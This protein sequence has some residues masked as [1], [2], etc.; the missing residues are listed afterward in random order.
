MQAAKTACFLGSAIVEMDEGYPIEEIRKVTQQLKPVG[1]GMSGFHTALIL[2]F[3]GEVAYGSEEAC[4]FAEAVQAHL[5]FG[6]LLASAELTKEFGVWDNS[7]VSKEYWEDHL[8]E[9]NDCLSNYTSLTK[10]EIFDV[11]NTFEKNGRFYNACT[12]S[13]APTG[14]VSQFLRNIDTGIEPFITVEGMHRRVRDAETGW[15]NYILH[16]IELYDL[17]E[18]DIEF[19]NRVESQTSE[20]I[21]PE[22]QL[23]ML[24][25]F[26]KYCHTGISKTINVPKSTTLG[27]VIDLIR[28]AKD[29]RLKGF[30]LYRM[31]SRDQVLSKPE[32]KMPDRTPKLPARRLGETYE[33]KGPLTAYITINQDEEERIREIF[34]QAGNI[35]TTLNSMFSAVGMLLSVSL[36]TNPDLI[37]KFIHTLSKVQ[38]GEFFSCD[39]GPDEDTIR[40]DSLP[41]LLSKILKGRYEELNKTSGTGTQSMKFESE[42]EFTSNKLIGDF[43]PGCHNLSLMKSGGCKD[44]HKC[45]HST[46]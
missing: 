42:L 45:G 40:G 37:D 29:Y 41:D 4:A 32:P 33:V 31:G 8:E 5:T 13:Q 16:P 36:R 14:S 18:K 2:A 11:Y 38:A 22:E 44:C 6:T 27:D 46:C 30:T 19:R 24:A 1:V 15:M 25:A 10:E 35:G 23:A 26:Q 43:C 34:V 12:T 20:T 17:L 9:L 28:K 7:E 39:L 21:N 3:N